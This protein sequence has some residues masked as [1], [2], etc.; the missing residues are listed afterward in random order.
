MDAKVTR[1]D[2]LRAAGLMGLGGLVWSVAARP[3]AA[4]DRLPPCEQCPALSACTL[5]ESLRARDALGL[6]GVSADTARLARL[7]SNSSGGSSDDTR[8]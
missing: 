2:V 8:L 1:R 7:C 3:A 5:P 4:T 6:H